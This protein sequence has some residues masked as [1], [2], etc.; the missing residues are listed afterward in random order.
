MREDIYLRFL[1]RGAAFNPVME[2]TSAWFSIN[3][4]FYLID[5]GETV[6]GKIWDK[7]EFFSAERIAVILTH[8]HADHVGSLGT[9][10]FTESKRIPRPLLMG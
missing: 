9:L 3:G 7:D 5:A 2:N 6:F 4:T 1:G 10:V 8:M